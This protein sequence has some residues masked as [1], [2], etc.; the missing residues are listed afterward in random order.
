MLS[1]TFEITRNG[2]LLADI[3]VVHQQEINSDITQL[4]VAML[5]G[6]WLYMLL[7]LVH[8]LS[9]STSNLPSYTSKK[10]FFSSFLIFWFIYCTWMPPANMYLPHMCVRTR[11]RVFSCDSV[12]PLLFQLFAC[13]RHVQGIVKYLKVFLRNLLPVGD[14]Q[15]KATY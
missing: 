5:R 12:C 9:A 15:T 4:V 1:D 11:G 10:I 7:L 8:A 6:M 2:V 14:Q 13:L 3:L